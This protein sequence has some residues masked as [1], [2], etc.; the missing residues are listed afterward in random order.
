MRRREFISLLG[1]AAA[2]WPLHARAQQ[3]EPMRRVGVLVYFTEPDL[4]LNAYI[5]EFR[6]Q[7]LTL[8][9]RNKVQIEYRW[10][11]GN[12]ELI[13][14]YPAELVALKPDVI[15]VAGGSHVGPLQQVTRAIPIVFVEVADAV[16]GGFV[17]SLARPGSNATGFT[18]Y[19][20][21]ISGKWLELLRQI[22]PGITRTA[23]LRDATNPSG[24]AQFGVIQGLARSLGVD[25]TPVGARDAAE[26]ERGISQFANRPNGGLIIAPNSFAL[27]H[28]ELIISLADQYKLPAIY[29]FRYFIKDGGLIS[30][31]PD[32]ADQYRRAAGYVDRIL[33]GERPADLPVQ[34]S[35]KVEL[36]INLTTAKA[37]S[38]E[39]PAQL[40][41]RADE[42][43][44]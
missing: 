31:G 25:V 36:V 42:V 5:E 37:L 21:D 2:T 40:L 16:G 38:L 39:V 41:A 19:E 29:P 4:T 14:Q 18:N 20:Y 27:S 3:P 44:E 15:L 26:V 30:Y 12:A 24:A 11:G 43:I 6:N 33:K 32:P 28:R 10:T 7:L 13:R 34:Q 8:G 35:T 22:A 23:F 9:W 17:D 1:G